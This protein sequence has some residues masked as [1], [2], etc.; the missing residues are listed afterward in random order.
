VTFKQLQDE[1]LALRFTGDES[2]RASAK[3]WINLSYTTIWDH[4]DWT[5]KHVHG[6]SLS[7]TTGD[8]TPTMPSDFGNA[9][10]LY[11]ANQD[12]MVY[13]DPIDWRDAFEN[14]A[15]TGPV[16]AYTVIDGQIYVGP[17]PSAG[18]T[19]TL[20]YTRR[21][22]H[23]DGATGLVAAGLMVNDSDQPVW[24]AEFD[25]LLVLDASTYGGSLLGDLDVQSVQQ[26]RDE[27]LAAMRNAMVGSVINERPQV[28]GSWPGDRFAAGSWLSP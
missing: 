8:T 3:S 11:D 15:A 13:L 2:R 4:D 9:E 26:K 27:L 17:V 20:D 12:Q 28:P 16:D 5:F 21:V 6:S 22:A 18:Q 24:N 7:V 1:I 10:A 25:Y 14:T 19:L 23:I